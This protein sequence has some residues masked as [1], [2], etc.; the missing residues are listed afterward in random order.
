MFN[1]CLVTTGESR[2]GFA[3][4]PAMRAVAD[5]ALN[6]RTRI[7]DHDRLGGSPRANVAGSPSIFAISP[8]FPNNVPILAS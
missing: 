2:S 8:S 1:Q 4:F 6:G 5:L 7:H 3:L